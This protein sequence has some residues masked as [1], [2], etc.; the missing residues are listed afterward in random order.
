MVERDNMFWVDNVPLNGTNQISIEATDA[1]GNVTTTNITVKASSLA[2]TIDTLPGGEELYWAGGSV[3]GTVGDPTATVS[4]NGTNA[5]VEATA[6]GEGSYNWSA[7]EVPLVGLGTSTFDAVA[8]T[9]GGVTTNASV[10]VEL[11]PAILLTHYECSGYGAFNYLSPYDIISTDTEK[12]DGRYEAGS[13]GQWRLRYQATER[14]TLESLEGGDYTNESQWS[15]PMLLSPE[16]LVV[17]DLSWFNPEVRVVHNFARGVRHAYSSGDPSGMDADEELMKDADTRW[18]LYTGGRSVVGRKSLFCLTA[19]GEGYGRPPHSGMLPWEATPMRVEGVEMVGKAVGGDGKLWVVEPDNATVD[20]NVRLPGAKHGSVSPGQSKYKLVHETFSQAFRNRNLERTDLGVG[21]EV[22]VGFEPPV[23]LSAP[24]INWFCW[25]GSVEADSWN[26][27]MDRALAAGVKFTAPSNEAA[28]LVGVTVKGNLL[29]VP[30]SV[31]EPS[32]VVFNK[33]NSNP[34]FSIDKQLKSYTSAG[35]QAVVKIMPDTVSFYRIM[36]I[37]DTVPATG[38]SGVWT[39]IT[40]HAI[41]GWNGV[42]WYNT[43]FGVDNVSSCWPDSGVF[44]GGYTWLIPFRYQVGY[45][46]NNPGKVFCTLHH[47]FGA[48]SNGTATQAKED[49]STAPIPISA[50]STDWP[51]SN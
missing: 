40:D 43:V 11:E 38:K 49:V 21:E 28:T 33:V 42:L 2:L 18:T 10:A 50:D 46:A 3:S 29:Y 19:M 8:S 39:N 31:Y 32:G 17:Y 44:P 23:P 51:F 12:Y 37:E 4:I 1:A 48:D 36:V 7:E 15:D 22:H 9:S 30:F 5:V 14:T 25:D 24:D 20:L 45:D 13:D 16:S 35:F 6:N 26:T 34:N 41:G 27:V 47:D